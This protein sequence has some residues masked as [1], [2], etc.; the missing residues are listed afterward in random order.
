[1]LAVWFY[2]ILSVLIVSLISLVG[3]FFLGMAV[4]KLRKIL[5][6]LISFSAGALF[7]DAF[8]HLFPEMIENGGFE[9]ISA[10]YVLSGILLFFILEK[11]IHWQ[12]CHMPITKEHAHPFAYMNLVGDS[13]HNFI[14][15]LIIAGSYLASIPTGIATTIAVILHEIPQEIGDFGVLIH[16]GFSK[17]KAIFMNFVT[18]LAAVVGALVALSLSNLI[19]NIQQIIVPLAIG[20]FLYIAGSDLIP[21]LHK[22]TKI[23]ISIR[24]IFAFVLGILIMMALLLLE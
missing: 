2:S 5:I 12:H 4:E 18:A 7:G 1:M 10:I 6:Y 13:L 11:V 23:S 22:E 16:G 19:S 21:E 20:G 14:D 8:I 3:V 9:L 15:G 24:Q 17:T